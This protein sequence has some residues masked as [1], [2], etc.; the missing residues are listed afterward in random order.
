MSA[1]SNPGWLHVAASVVFFSAD[2]GVHGPVDEVTTGLGQDG[3]GDVLG[4]GVV[5]HEGAHEVEV[6]LRGGR[7]AHLDLLEAHG[8]EQVEHPTL[9][10]GAHGFDEGLVAVAQVRGEPA[11]R[12]RDAPR[13]PPAVG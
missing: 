5:R 10:L 9:G 1:D 7:E 8:H 3:D 6:G 2:D 4:H 13:G 11:G 12:L